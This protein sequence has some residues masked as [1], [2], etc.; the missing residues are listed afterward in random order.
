[1]IKKSFK[2]FNNDFPYYHKIRFHVH[3]IACIFYFLFYNGM[4]CILF[5][6]S[7]CARIFLSIIDDLHSFRWILLL[8][9]H[10]FFVQII[11]R[12]LLKVKMERT[13]VTTAFSPSSTE[14][15]RTLPNLFKL[16][17]TLITLHCHSTCLCH[18]GNKTTFWTPQ[19]FSLLSLSVNSSEP[20]TWHLFTPQ[21]SLCC[22]S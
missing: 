4:A 19:K 1:M 18:K 3:G 6:F 9:R 8:Y 14:I 13:T 17:N 16:Q 7:S 5:L 10:L 12:F 15:N 22:S 20:H 2:S 21:S 11:I